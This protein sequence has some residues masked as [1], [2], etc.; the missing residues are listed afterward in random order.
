MSKDLSTLI[1]RL[2]KAGLREAMSAF[3]RRHRCHRVMEGA[4]YCGLCDGESAVEDSEW[5]EA[6]HEPG[7]AFL[8]AMQAKGAE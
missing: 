2:E 3:W 6:P 5:F 7:C 4:I 8:K 1:E